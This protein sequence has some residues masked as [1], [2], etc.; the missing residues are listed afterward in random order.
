MALFQ[1]MDVWNLYPTFAQEC[2]GTAEPE[3][4]TDAPEVA[5]KFHHWLVNN[6]DYNFNQIT[7]DGETAEWFWSVVL[8]QASFDRKKKRRYPCK[9]KTFSKQTRGPP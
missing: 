8:C 3:M 5:M 7:E 4:M 6:K 2:Y 9:Q 1:S